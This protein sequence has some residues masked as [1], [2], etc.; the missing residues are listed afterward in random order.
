MGPQDVGGRSGQPRMRHRVSHEQHAAGLAIT[1][2]NRQCCDKPDARMIGAK[3]TITFRDQLSLI[4][5]VVHD[6][7]FPGTE[8]HGR[9]QNPMRAGDIDRPI[10]AKARRHP[11]VGS[12]FSE[13][14]N[15]HRTVGR[16]RGAAREL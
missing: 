1:T 16:M 9:H 5:A 3:K 12:G 7:E 15:G 10:K 6:Q 4:I 14:Q 2:R 13:I 8:L 11:I